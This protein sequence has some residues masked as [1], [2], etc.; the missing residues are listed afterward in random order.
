M[1]RVNGAVIARA[2]LRIALGGGSTDLSSHYRE[3]GGFVLS[4][5][6]DRY[7]RMRVSPSRGELFR[8][9][10]L[11]REEV[12][13]AADIAHPILRAAIARHGNGRPLDL[14]SE[15]DVPPGTGLGSSGAYAVCAVK[16]IG[17][18][19]AREL[20]GGALA[21]AACAI[22]IERAHRRQAG[23]VR[24]GPWRCQLVHLRA[25]RNGRSAPA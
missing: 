2:P 14:S 12:V 10:H 4:A 17:M 7:V 22:E 5:A 15:G 6:I 1:A 21:E 3:H 9:A 11:E 18:S 13:N 20:T 8:L 19:A 16:A 24:L 23:S 25:R